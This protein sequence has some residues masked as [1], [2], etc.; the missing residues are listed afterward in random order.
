MS[1]LRAALHRAPIRAKLL[2][3]IAVMSMAIVIATTV[4]LTTRHNRHVEMELDEKCRVYARLLAHQLEPAVAFDDRATAQE[5]FASFDADEDVDGLALYRAGGALIQGHG[6]F[7]PIGP[8]AVQATTLDTHE[9]NVVARAPVVAREGP[10]GVLVVSMGQRGIDAEKR[11]AG[12]IAAAVGLAA[13]AAALVVGWLV[14]SSVADRLARIAGAASRVAKGDLEGEPVEAGALDEIGQLA[15]AFNAMVARLKGLIGQIEHSARDEQERLTLLVDERT[16]E[17]A[18]RTEE[19]AQAQKLESVGRLAAGVAHEINTPIQFVSDSVHFV[20]DSVRELDV[21]LGAHRAVLAAVMEGAPAREAALAAARVEEEIDLEYI[22]EHVPKA[23]DRALD[24]IARV[25]TIV[26]SM[27]EFAHPTRSEMAHADINQAISATLTI[28]RNEYKYVADLE[29]ELG[30][31]PPVVC[32]VGEIN[33]AVL[34]IVVNAAHA[35]GDAVQ[36]TD[37]KGRITVQTRREADAVVI[38]IG[39]T[40]GGIP[41]DV[42]GRVFDPFFTMKEVGKGTGQGLAIARAVV[43]EKHRGSLRFETEPGHG[44]TFI[45]R[46]PIDGAAPG[47]MKVAA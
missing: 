39:D 14:A 20:R 22:T 32:N 46:L 29:T 45:L 44:T 33:Q 37:R 28:A 38:S 5:V 19:L 18:A 12:A 36:G 10:R 43:V 26:R 1:T 25:V 16:R 7:A 13:M 30:D 23:L 41:A 2:L 3:G 8:A 9:G 17:L 31:L 34:N 27:K 40:G 35:I 47:S 4:A 21:A 6:R 15:M 24:G 11:T 42:Q